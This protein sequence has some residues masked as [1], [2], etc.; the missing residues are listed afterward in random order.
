MGRVNFHNGRHPLHFS[1]GKLVQRASGEKQW[2]PPI[3]GR[4]NFMMGGTLFSPGGSWFKGLRKAVDYHG[5]GQFHD[6]RHP[7]LSRGNQLPSV[8]EQGATHHEFGTISMMG[9]IP[10]SLQGEVGSKG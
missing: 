8:I 1:R 4:V 6:G 2:M 9:G 10:A 5:E 7:V 3:M